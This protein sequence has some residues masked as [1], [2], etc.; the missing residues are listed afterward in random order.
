[1][2]FAFLSSM[3]AKMSRAWRFS[4]KARVGVVEM[5]DHKTEVLSEQE[6]GRA[7]SVREWQCWVG[8]RALQA[9]RKFFP[10][11]PELSPPTQCSLPSLHLGSVAKISSLG[12]EI[13]AFPSFFLSTH[14]PGAITNKESG[15]PYPLGKVFQVV[16]PKIK[17]KRK[18]AGQGEGNF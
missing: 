9:R 7:P 15:C 4:I 12:K 16:F 11:R 8:L 3:F 5:M 6:K 17:C 2:K 1:M 14:S 10:S 18:W 13:C